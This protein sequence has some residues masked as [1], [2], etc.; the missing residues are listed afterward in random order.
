MTK[1]NTKTEISNFSVIQ[2]LGTLLLAFAAADFVFIL[3]GNKSYSH[4]WDAHLQIFTN[5]LWRCWYCFN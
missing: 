4:L 3:D 1:I 5:Y 2:V